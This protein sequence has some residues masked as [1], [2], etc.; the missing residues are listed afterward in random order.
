MNY[1]KVTGEMGHQG[2]GKSGDIVF[3]IEA[4]SIVNACNYVKKMPG[5]KKHKNVFNAK[6]ISM[7]EYQEGRMVS[8]YAPYYK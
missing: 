1:F 5:V 3:Y 6:Q 2:A 8:A 4:D 7:K